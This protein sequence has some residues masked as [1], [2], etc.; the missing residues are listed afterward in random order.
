MKLSKHGLGQRVEEREVLVV[1]Y[2]PARQFPHALLV[3]EIRAVGRQEVQTQD[4]AV[5][6]EPRLQRLGVM[7]FGVVNND[8][9]DAPGAPVSHEMSQERLKGFRIERTQAIR[10]EPSVARTHRPED[11]HALARGRME[12]HRIG[13]IR[14]HPHDAARSVLLEVAF[15]FKPQLKIAL[16]R[17]NAKFFYM[18]VGL[19]GPL[20]Q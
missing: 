5:C 8:D 12:H 19:P 10:H 2:E 15:I 3:V 6:V 4:V 11:R 17:Q 1:R 20:W 7:V 9:L 18:P 14:W 13:Q 16:P